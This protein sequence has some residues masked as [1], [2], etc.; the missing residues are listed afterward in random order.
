MGIQI[1]TKEEIHT[2]EI[3]PCTPMEEILQPQ[4]DTGMGGKT[5]R[6]LETCKLVKGVEFIQKRFFLLFKNDDSEKR[7]QEKLRICLCSG[8]REEEI[9]YKEKLKEELRE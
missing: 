3:F 7:L 5:I 4:L 1:R 8:Q 6:Y 2:L 9:A